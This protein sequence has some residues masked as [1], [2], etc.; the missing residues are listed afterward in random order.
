V[1]SETRV[2]NVRTQS[3]ASCY[4]PDNPVYLIV[5][6]I[7]FQLWHRANTH[8]QKRR[9]QDDGIWKATR[10]PPRSFS[11]ACLFLSRPHDSHHRLLWRPHTRQMRIT[12]LVTRMPNFLA[13]SMLGDAQPR[14]VFS[15]LRSSLLYLL[16]SFL[17]LLLLIPIFLYADYIRACSDHFR[18]CHNVGF[19]VFTAVMK[20]Y[21]AV[22]SG[23]S[24]LMFQRKTSLPCSGRGV[25]QPQKLGN[26]GRTI[27]HSP[28]TV[29]VSSGSGDPPRSL[30]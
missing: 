1:H 11:I 26:G 27:S 28:T 15:V 16:L 5:S 14:C 2:Q 10:V 18:Y 12:L 7:W 24:Q 17:L 22:Q 6:R 3:E 19:E 9:E 29:A 25:S 20:R 13:L 30:P 4:R 23:E 8:T 21:N